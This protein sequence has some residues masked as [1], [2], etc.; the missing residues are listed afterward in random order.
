MRVKDRYE[1]ARELGD[2]YAAARRAER[3]EIL[4]GFCLATGCEGKYAIKVLRGRQ[5]KAIRRSQPRQR[6]YGLAFR[7]ALK[8]FWEASGY[9]GNRRNVRRQ[10]V[11]EQR[12]HVLGK[13]SFKA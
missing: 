8:V 13:R 5:R 2:R 12:L 11:A 6:R 7:H 3:T 1:L 10:R 4:N 9:F